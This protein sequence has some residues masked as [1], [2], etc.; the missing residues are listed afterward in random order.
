[1]GIT[2]DSTHKRRATGGKKK[3]WHK[4]R[5]YALGRPAAMTK[6][7]AKRIHPVRVRGGSTKYRA[8]RLES[9]NFSWGS[10]V[11]TRKTRILN[12]VYNPSNNEY[13]RTNTLVKN[14]V[15]QIDSTPFRQWYEQH[16]GI[17]L[18]KK[19]KAEKKEGEEVEV[20]KGKN[21]IA[22]QKKRAEKQVLSPLL[23]DQFGAG[24]LYALVSSRPGQSGRCDGYILEGPELEF[25]LKKLARKKE[26]KEK[27]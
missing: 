24:R 25:Y 16:Y 8:L 14:T 20:K 26:K 27:A 18:G 7:G 17:S 12:C 13:V 6:L 22:K 1:M 21:A 2:R 5:K 10:E 15:V 23:E 19:K 11:V 9:G 4:K 3:P